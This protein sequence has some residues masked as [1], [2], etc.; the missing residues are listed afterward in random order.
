MCNLTSCYLIGNALS[1]HTLSL[2]MYCS[3]ILLPNKAGRT[4]IIRDP[5]KCKEIWDISG[6]ANRHLFTDVYGQGVTPSWS[7][8]P[9]LTCIGRH[10]ST[11]YTNISKLFHLVL[12]I[13]NESSINYN[14][15]FL[16]LNT[17]KILDKGILSNNHNKMKITVDLL[18]D[19]WFGS[20]MIEG[21][22]NCWSRNVSITEDRRIDHRRS[23]NWSQ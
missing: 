10:F 12:T 18:T 14:L 11:N 3:V 21:F 9:P 5:E 6:I 4:E 16:F 2:R 17:C 7:F 19:D 8:T 22:D 15:Y 23:K 13:W 20:L 1:Y